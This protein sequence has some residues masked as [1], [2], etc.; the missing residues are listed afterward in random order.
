MSDVH[1]VDNS[2]MTLLMWSCYNG[3][4]TVAK[5]LLERGADPEEKDIEGKTA[6]HWYNRIYRDTCR[7][8]I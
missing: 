7:C 5:Y 3:N 1:V 6:M 8:A 2:D 4:V